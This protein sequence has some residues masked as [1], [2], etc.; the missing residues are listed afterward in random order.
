LV[1]RKRFSWSRLFVDLENVLPRAVSVD[2]INVR[3][4]YQKND[5]TVAELEFAVL[6]RDYQAVLEMINSMNNSS[7]FEA[8][9]RGQNLQSDKG[10]LTEYT[11]QLRYSPSSGVPIKTSNE[12]NN[13]T[14][15]QIKR[16]KVVL[17]NVQ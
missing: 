10:N 3:D 13:S 14:T 16:E 9:L 11:I 1:A 17:E 12:E 8:E 7:I 4:V 6:S 5:R 2:H 15:A